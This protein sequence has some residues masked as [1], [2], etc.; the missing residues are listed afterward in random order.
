MSTTDKRI[1]QMQFD[2]KLFERN[3]ETTRSTIKNLKK[4]LDFESSVKQIS[5]LTKAGSNFNL[6]GMG[7]SI[8]N[9]TQRLTAMTVVGITALQNLT[10]SAINAGKRMVSALTID[11]VMTGLQEYEVKMDA[12]KTIL[13]NT[14]RKGSTLDD[15]N[16]ALDDLNIYADK[17]IYNFA[18]MTDMVGKFAA[19]SGDLDKS[20]NIVKGLSNLAASAGVGNTQLQ[21]ALYQTAQATSGS[22]FQK[23][24][25]MSLENANMS[26]QKFR[27]DLIAMGEQ[28]GTFKG[29]EGTLKN[30]KNNAVDFGSTL[31][32]K[33]LTTDVFEAV[34]AMYALDEAMTKA[35]GEVTTLTKLFDTM[36]ETVQSGWT[37]T[38]E[39]ILGNQQEATQL[40]T[41]ISEAF[42][43][44]I[45][46]SAGARNSMLQFWAANE[47]R[48][49][50]LEGLG[51]TLLLIASAMAPFEKALSSVFPPMTG[52]RL[53]ELSKN[54]RD[55]MAGFK[56]SEETADKLQRTFQGLFSVLDIVGKG[57]K[58]VAQVAWLLVKAIAPGAGGLLSL[59][60]GIGDFLTALNNSVDESGFFIKA[61]EK[62][63]DVIAL[64]AGFITK[65]IDKIIEKFGLMDVSVTDVIH[66]VG[67]LLG[68][69]IYDWT[70]AA[71]AT[72]LF[73]K[74]TSKIGGILTIVGNKMSEIFNIIRPGKVAF[75][76]Y[77]EEMDFSSYTAEKAAV[78]I[79]TLHSIFTKI[80]DVVKTVAGAIKT[81]LTPAFTYIKDFITSIGGGEIAAVVAGGGLLAFA[82]TLSDIFGTLKGGIDSVNGILDSFA[83]IMDNVGGT[84][85]AFQKKVK[86][87]ALVKVATALGILAAALVVLSFIDGVALAKSL[88]ALGGAL[89]VL[90]GGMAVLNKVIK[91]TKSISGQMIAISAALVILSLAVKNIAQIEDAKLIQS[92]S[93]I[94]ALMMTLALFMKA[95]NGADLAASSGGLIGF[96]TG[97]T[98]LVGAI[99]IF[100]KMDEKTIKQGAV[101]LALLMGVLAT[102]IKLTNG[103]DLVMSAGGLIGFATGITILVGAIAIFGKMDETKIK[104]GTV[105]L[106]LLMATIATFIKLTDGGDLA[107]SAA[108]IIA[109]SIGI[110]IMVSAILVLGKIKTE[111]VI[112]GI[113]AISSLMLAIAAFV[114]V[115]SGGDLLK[116]SAGMGAFAAAL[117]VLTKSVKVLAKLEF[118]KVV[119]GVGAI[120][121]LISVI[122]LFVDITRGGDLAASSAGIIAFSAGIAIL[123][124]SL[125]LLSTIKGEKLLTAVSA[126]GSLIV[127]IGAFVKMTKGGDLAMSS[128]G[129]MGFALGIIAIAGAVAILSALNQE[130]LLLAT[131]AISVLMLSVAAFIK[132][133][134]GGE[135]VAGVA[136]MIGFAAAI[137]ILVA[138][139]LPI[140]ALDTVKLLSATAAITALM[141]GF[142]LFSKMIS[143][144]GLVTSAAALV[145][146]SAGVV[147]LAGALSTLGSLSISE[148][149]LGL[150]GIAAAFVVLG[151]AALVLTPL[152]PVILALSAALAILGVGALGIGVGLLSLANGLKIVA[153]GGQPFIDAITNIINLIPLMIQ[154][155]AEGVVKFAETI[156]NGMP[157]IISALTALTDGLVHVFI[158]V[159]PRIAEAIVL[160]LEAVLNK[161]AEHINPIIEAGMTIVL[162]I[163]TGISNRAYEL[164]AMA[165][166]LM[167][168]LLNAI[169]SKIP[170]IV[171]AGINIVTALTDAVGN[172][173]PRLVDA[174]FKMIIDFVNGLGD[175]FEERTPELVTAVFDLGGSIVKGLV[176]GIFGGL[177]SVLETVQ[178]LGS[179][180]IGGFK[181]LLDINS[182][183]KV[184]SGFGKNIVDGL[185][186]GIDN[187]AKK[188]VK[189]ANSLANAVT[190]KTRQSFDINS[191]SGV[192]EAIGKFLVGGLTKGVDES[193]D[194]AVA[195][196]TDMVSETAKASEEV[197]KDTEKKTKSAFETA[198]ELMEEKKFFGKMTLQDEYDFWADLQKKYKTGTDERKR[199]ER[200]LYTLKNALIKE[201]YDNERERIDDLKFYGKMSTQ[202]ELDALEKL[203][204]QY[205]EGS[206]ERKKLDKETYTLRNKLVTE[207]YD[208]E[209]ERID[210]LK[211]Y[212][213]M[214]T[215]EELD[216][217]DA[218]SKK[219]EESSDER[220]K[221]DKET[222][223]LRN[224]LITE[225][226]ND[227]IDKIEELKFYGKMTQYQELKA[228]EYLQTKYVEGSAE[229]IKI[230]KNVYTIK[231]NL[232]AKQKQL[233]EDYLESV[234]RI[235]AQA[236]S[237][238]QKLNDDF[239]QQFINRSKALYSAYNLFEEI[240]EPEWVSGHQLI[241]NLETQIQA[242]DKWKTAINSLTTKNVDSELMTELIAMGPSASANI[243]ALNDLSEPELAKYVELWRSKTESA[244][245]QAALEMETQRTEMNEKMLLI[246]RDMETEL[247]TLKT[248]WETATKALTEGVSVNLETLETTFTGSVEEI[249]TATTTTLN[250]MIKTIKK[251]D[252]SGVGA[253][254]VSGMVSGINSNATSLANAAAKVAKDA[255]KAAKK[256]LD[257]NSPSREFA[258]LGM[259]SD[260]GMA[261]G[262]ADN[263]DLV[264]AEA[265]NV[266]KGAIDAMKN[267]I[268]KISEVVDADMDVV[269]VITPVLD[270]SGIQNGSKQLYSMLGKG[271][272]IDTTSI[273]KAARQ[274]G[275]NRSVPVS[276]EVNKNVEPVTN[277]T[278][279]QNN[280][281]PKAL[282]HIEIYRQTKNQL[283]QL[284][285]VIG[286][287]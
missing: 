205:A 103:G 82:K 124:T 198:I 202:E 41:G 121:V 232:I 187:N 52:E 239:T 42:G 117:I 70:G 126:I 65:G 180:V 62:V 161:I 268:L 143:P 164:T 83:G 53:V 14:S 215:Q 67:A 160:M 152:T 156:T 172:E 54:F 44:M 18:Q 149:L 13:G 184:F 94:G 233:E 176:N 50:V 267:A 66:E 230:D 16:A 7:K 221:L 51:H 213:K 216:A 46:V 27:E 169:A 264:T 84:L 85:K 128:A 178:E 20:V 88:G 286:T 89:V 222:Y 256:A 157:T 247:D 140:A 6:G 252:W 1:V 73:H 9:V 266:G 181:K 269:P 258:K 245:I 148:L 77:N 114:N 251:M 200:E 193:S 37:G 270:L 81:A 194:E 96:A 281:S 283:S 234:S 79:V 236:Q 4:D 135:I 162:A 132:I 244:S 111:T 28:M 285:G 8:D 208:E 137:G 195:A 102:F 56:I 238:M 277:V 280:Y 189:S 182:P 125:M 265:S 212:G 147:L 138:S 123:S 278:L 61:L 145:V 183:S 225:S 106:A 32:E 64:V 141:L 204:K 170:D 248:T 87:Q 91:E 75:A 274:A 254:I 253:D 49:A 260:M 107:G 25:W 168:N 273:N 48:Q 263:A 250:S 188:A 22:Y 255:L 271:I 241:A 229:R 217:I 224:K 151:V 110:Q 209:R 155:V 287:T 220:K 237:D 120:T 113:A 207:A 39:A 17:T 40:F 112:Q 30:L 47:G 275:M 76:A 71:N 80:V 69:W 34:A 95:T 144:A 60:A 191:P 276:S 98:I 284:K 131:T 35:A 55:F 104:Q 130:K 206:D 74:I 153:D 177:G 158:S 167:V 129:I 146:M 203:S 159:I 109:F 142:A 243:Q 116:S 12:I 192:F 226:Y 26:T 23:I 211:F 5:N 227:E 105:A 58:F 261:E 197:A 2:N 3:A 235:Q 108:G 150:G 118:N 15:V 133:T 93:A 134:N 59:T 163:L 272:N 78:A 214:S 45:E 63:S 201:A 231:E 10:N 179:T 29:L 119:Q 279:N 166:E 24:D 57:F 219:Y 228:L 186:N 165:I 174:G 33:W 171:A 36:Q 136:G 38:W 259:Y 97:I 21:S 190:D 31:S 127:V 240:P 101:S 72:E 185:T 210:D 223:T 115:T 139:I 86:A 173:V 196:S 99:A 92:V 19:S 257:I 90:V 175:A 100:G 68:T 262:F 122:A 246:N 249:K 11:P 199:I 43:A 242:F 154:K 218:L 282:S